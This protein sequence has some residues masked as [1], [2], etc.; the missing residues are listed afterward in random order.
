SRRRHTRS[1][2]DWSSHVCSSD[3]EQIVAQIVFNVAPGVED[4]RAR[5][6]A[7]KSLGD[8]GS[9][10]QHGIVGHVAQRAAMFDDPHRLANP[11]GNRSEERRV[12]KE[13]KRRVESK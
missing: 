8:G 7:D 2:G 6:G 10:D 9:D 12:G 13:W 1:Y 3:L 11:P 5:I 4:Q